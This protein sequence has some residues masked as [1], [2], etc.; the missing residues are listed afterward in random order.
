M[1]P[2][3]SLAIYLIYVIGVVFVF[4]YY[5]EETESNSHIADEGFEMVATTPT[6]SAA[7][8]AK[9]R[10]KD[11]SKTASTVMLEDSSLLVSPG[12]GEGSA[13]NSP[14]AGVGFFSW[15]LVADGDVGV[16]TNE[17][18]ESVVKLPR[19]GDHTFRHWLRGS[20]VAVAGRV[21]LKSK[22]VWEA[23]TAPVNY[24]IHRVLPSLYMPGGHGEEIRQK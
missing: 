8:I 19:T 15:G 11:E 9:S 10:T 7:G 5:P 13:Q 12:G 22:Q 16:D 14:A 23:I 2:L 24:A 18:V 6:T 3:A 21:I 4:W 20:A 1:R 17:D